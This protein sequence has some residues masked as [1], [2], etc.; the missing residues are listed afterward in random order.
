MSRLI[1]RML[2]S[3]SRIVLAG[4]VLWGAS[5]VVRTLGASG[6]DDALDRVA[7]SK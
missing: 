6:T 5:A 3:V 7:T 2:Q 1:L 4:L